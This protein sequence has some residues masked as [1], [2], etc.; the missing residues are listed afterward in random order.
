MACLEELRALAATDT[1]EAARIECQI[2]ELSDI[3]S[4]Y[5]EHLRDVAILSDRYNALHDNVRNKAY[6]QLRQ[7]RRAMAAAAV[8]NDCMPVP[9]SALLKPGLSM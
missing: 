3:Y 2:E 4:R 6:K 8:Q 7:A 1:S 5:R 9:H